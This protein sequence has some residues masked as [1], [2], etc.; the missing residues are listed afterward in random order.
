MNRKINATFLVG[1]LVTVV[2]TGAAMAQSKEPPANPL[3]VYSDPDDVIDRSLYGDSPADFEYVPGSGATTR[4]SG[5]ARSNAAATPQKPKSSPPTTAE[6]IGHEEH[7]WSEEEFQKLGV[8][9]QNGDVRA[10]EELAD[11]YRD[12][13]GT[14]KDEEKALEWYKAAAEAG[15][16]SSYSKIGDLYRDYGAQEQG[17]GML[18]GIAAKLKGAMQQ[19]GTVIEKDNDLAAQWYQKGVDA[20]DSNSFMRLGIMYR[21]GVGVPKNSGKAKQYYDAGMSL[22][23][24][25][26]EE[27]WDKEAVRQRKSAERAEK[28]GGGAVS[29]NAVPSGA[30]VTIDGVKCSLATSSVRAANFIAVY[31][32][33]C[34]GLTAANTTQEH[35]TELQDLDC[36]VQYTGAVASHRLFCSSTRP[37]IVISGAG[38]RLQAVSPAQGYSAA[39]DVFCTGAAD[40]S[41]KTVSHLGMNCEVTAGGAGKTYAL[42]C[43]AA[44]ATQTRTIKLGKHSCALQPVT[45]PSAT[46]NVYYEAYCGGLTEEQKKAA[47]I[48]QTLAIGQNNCALTAWPAN[49]QNK[50][51]EI[52][53]I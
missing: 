16:V 51:F 15:S 41:V 12:G 7:V 35:V 36:Q 24:D 53:C 23:Q 31:D 4:S 30:S 22:R 3:E 38:C 17:G 2:L 34:P 33:N 21:D 14:Q 29:P 26:Q 1:A 37:D 11:A 39:Y 49:P 50:D 44:A 19:D 47:D 5:S 6:T 46:Y 18:S 9:A 52:G 28:V 8:R 25:K 40:A 42:Q 10:A 48:P 32:A 20:K 45:P 13:N 27:F 43:R